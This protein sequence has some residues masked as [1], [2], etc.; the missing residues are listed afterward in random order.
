MHFKVHQIVVERMDSPQQ[1]RKLVPRGALSRPISKHHL[2]T[3]SHHGAKEVVP[4]LNIDQQCDS[5]FGDD[6]EL[7]S[8][9]LKLDA[10]NPIR[11]V[12]EKTQNLTIEDPDT[13]IRH[14]SPDSSSH[15]R[16]PLNEELFLNYAQQDDPRYLLAQEHFRHLLF[17]QDVDGDT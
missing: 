16:L 11:S 15:E 2:S 17:A 9:S 7:R 5:G 6:E 10:E 4:N 1:Q 8:A 12:E 13:N 14:S 3:V